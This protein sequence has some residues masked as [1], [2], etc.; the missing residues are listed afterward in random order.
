MDD[1][2]S[3]PLEPNPKK[4]AAPEQDSP[5]RKP[6]NLKGNQF[7]MPTPPDTDNSS[8]VSPAADAN[9]DDNNTRA[10]S[11]AP[12]SSGSAL[13]SVIENTHDT[14]VQN[15]ATTV[16]ASSSGPPPAKRRKLTP[17][18]RLEKQQ[19]KEAKERE[20][21]EQKARKDEEKRL[22][23]DEKRRKA[24][25]REA[26]KRVHDEE[27][28]RIAEEKEAKKREK[29]LKEEQKVQDK[30]KKERSQMR[31]GAFFQRGPATPAKTSSA[32]ADIDDHGDAV[33]R[34][35]RRSLS[36]DL[37]DNVAEQIKTPAKDTPPPTSVKKPAPSVS[38]YHKTFL[39]F[40][41]QSHCRMPPI[42]QPA[43]EAAQDAFEQELRNP[44]LKEKFDLGLI[45]LYQEDAEMKQ[46]FAGHVERGT[47][48]PD[49][50]VL[51]DTISG[52]SRQPIDLT[53]EGTSE[54]ALVR[55]REVPIRYVHFDED[56]RPAYCGTYTKIRSPRTVRKVK[57]NP[58]TRARPDTNYDY[59]SE[60]EWEE[61]KEDDEEI[62]SEEEDEADSQADGNEINDFLDDEDDDKSKRKIITSELVPESTGL[63]WLGCASQLENSPEMEAMRMGILLSSFTGTTIDPFSTAYWDSPSSQPPTVQLSEKPASIRGPMPPPRLPLQPRL[64]VNGGLDKALDVVGATA[65]AKG[66]IT[67]SAIVPGAKRGP[68]PAPK[69]LSREDMAEFTEAIVGSDLGKL[70]LQKG[71]KAK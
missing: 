51:M 13:S 3:S 56:V 22:Q 41:L 23:D 18:E 39:P 16:G 42:P 35:R 65:G 46:C 7:M 26:K 61:P 27:K 54:G 34:A 30:L 45:D 43:S 58:F 47:L 55:L 63:C 8:N 67:S 68:K 20:K 66:P 48:D 57:R 11:P 32:S 25:D 24:E 70:E 71:L 59:D 40:E 6:L 12:S 49:I 50:Q 36:L 60:A 28:R 37:Y 33:T 4:R 2:V 17:A 38:D 52:T 53:G 15:S 44:S 19:I 21:A 62:L 14:S 5:G 31:L 10:A 9:N 64:N 69:T 1:I 29:E